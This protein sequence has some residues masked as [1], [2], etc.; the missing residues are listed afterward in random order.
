MRTKRR[1]SLLDVTWQDTWHMP[2]SSFHPLFTREI[3]TVSLRETFP[4]RTH[5]RYYSMWATS[6]RW[7]SSH[8]LLYGSRRPKVYASS[9]TVPKKKPLLFSTRWT[10]YFLFVTHDRQQTPFLS[11][12]CPRKLENLEPRDLWR[13]LASTS[14]CGLITP[15]NEQLVCMST[16]IF[17][18]MKLTPHTGR[19]KQFG[20]PWRHPSNNSIVLFCGLRGTV[21]SDV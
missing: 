21:P 7:S 17:L 13:K 5:N 16:I 11:P 10:L 8:V 15:D 2:L 9:L 18:I 20:E 6:I 14:R 1:V 12:R 19:M 4:R 3:N